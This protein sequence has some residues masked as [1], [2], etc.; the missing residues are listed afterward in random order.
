MI[1]HNT[2]F[3]KVCLRMKKHTNAIGFVLLIV[4]ATVYY[5]KHIAPNQANWSA[6][7]RN[8]VHRIVA[9]NSKGSGTSIATANGQTLVITA[10]HVVRDGGPYTVADLPARVIAT[11]STWDL[12]ALVVDSTMLSSRLSRHQP[13]NGDTMTVCGY[14]SGDYGENTGIVVGWGSPGAGQPA[15]WVII[16][17]R[18]RSGDSG[19]PLF[20]SDG[21]VGAVLWGSDSSGAHGTPCVRVRN[22]LLTITGYDNLVKTALSI[23]YSIW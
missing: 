5:T 9:G 3:L 21:T 6:E 23:D 17:A 2:R 10:W 18:A 15:D 4:A 8:T 1:H 19:G 13:K 11:D 22:F 16:N 14:G 12:A 20:Y 7:P